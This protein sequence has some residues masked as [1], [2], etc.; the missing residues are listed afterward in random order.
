MLSWGKLLNSIRRKALHGSA[1]SIGTGVAAHLARSFGQRIA[2]MMLFVPFDNLVSVGQEKM[3][4]LPVRAILW[5]RFD[6]AA[7]MKNY[8]GPVRFMLAEKDEIIPSKFGLR[9]HD[10][11]SGPKMLE[12]ASGAGHNDVSEQSSEWWK[13]VF[14]FWREHQTAGTQED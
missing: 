7:W 11:Y 4:L 8:R 9:L 13:K 14:A 1:E 2:G 5:D 6:P 12:I 3:P 10:G